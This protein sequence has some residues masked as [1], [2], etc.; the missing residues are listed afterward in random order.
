M[1][2][3]CCDVSFKPRASKAAEAVGHRRVIHIAWRSLR[4]KLGELGLQVTRNVGAG[5]AESL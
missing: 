4:T 5:E 2:G 3:R 1:W